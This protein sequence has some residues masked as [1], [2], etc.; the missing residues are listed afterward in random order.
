MDGMSVFLVLRGALRKHVAPFVLLLLC[1]GR[2][3]IERGGFHGRAFFVG[4]AAR[5]F[6]LVAL[7]SEEISFG[8]T[9]ALC[10]LEVKR[11]LSGVAWDT[12]KGP[13]TPPS[14]LL[15]GRFKNAPSSARS[16]LSITLTFHRHTFSHHSSFL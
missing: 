15:F 6:C 10:D 14:P 8:V 9:P 3:W 2:V 7:L 4:V 13:V 16:R 1:V 12:R 5:V 11:T